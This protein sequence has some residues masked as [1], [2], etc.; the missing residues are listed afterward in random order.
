MEYCQKSKLLKRIVYKFAKNRAE[1]IFNLIEEFLNKEEIILD[2]GCGSCNIVE[3]LNQNN[4]NVVSLDIKNLSIVD[5]IKPILYNGTNMPFKDNTFDL[6]IILTVLHHTD[7]QDEVL[8]EAMRVTKKRILII[9]DIYNNQIDKFIT[10]IVDSL[11]NL[12]IRGHPHSN[13]NDQEW[14]EYFKNLGL[15][16]SETKYPNRYLVFKPV[17]YELEKY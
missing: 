10:Q 12:E 6:S 1:Q 4:Y 14:K 16:I 5:E 13:R 11:I 17:I 7:K 8:K 9:E 3:I 2:I 15:K